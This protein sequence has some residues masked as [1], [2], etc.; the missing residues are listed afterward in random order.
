MSQSLD[1][2]TADHEVPSQV[3]L[4]LDA[5]VHEVMRTMR[6]MRRLRPDPVPTELLEQLVEA[7]TW[8]PSGSNAQAYSWVVVTDRTKMRSLAGLWAACFDLYMGTLGSLSNETLDTAQFERIRRASA[9]QRD[10]FA[11]TAAVIVPCYELRRQRK[12]LVRAWRSVVHELA[13]LDAG[14]RISL[15]Q[16]GR[17][18]G[19]MAEAA[20]VYPGVQNLLLTARAL[21]LGATITTWHLLLEREFKRVLGVPRSV[22]TFAVIPVGWPVGN[23]G[24]VRR[25]PG[26]EAIHWNGW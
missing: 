19:E 25:R 20:S 15:L 4:G 16:G 8:A 22:K 5:R 23:L 9:Y 6:A 26:S 13:R 21:G 12:E 14:G 11:A 10:H 7:A 1:P 24:P 17:R 2:Q 3:P 18:A